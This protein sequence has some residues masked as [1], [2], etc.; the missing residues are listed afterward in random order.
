[1]GIRKVYRHIK[2]MLLGDQAEIIRKEAEEL[3]KM[4]GWKEV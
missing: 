4:Y 2:K 1:M 3:E